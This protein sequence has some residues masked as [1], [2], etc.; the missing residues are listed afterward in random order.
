MR[1]DSVLIPAGV[2]Q[3]K[4]FCQ[5]PPPTAG[6]LAVLSHLQKAVD[7]FV[8]SKEPAE[9]KVPRTPTRDWAELMPNL[10]VT[11]HREVAL[12]AHAMTAKQVTPWLPPP[13]LGG[14]AALV[15]VGGSQSS[16]HPGE[17]PLPESNLLEG[18]P[19]A[20]VHATRGEW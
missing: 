17:C 18:I 7:Y 5:L 9:V 11:Y 10:S 2:A 15:C 8:D 6:Q 12:E 4:T 16:L 3:P 14:S 1:G 19:S 13:G 20:K